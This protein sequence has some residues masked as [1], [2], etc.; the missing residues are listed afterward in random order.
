M[1][2]SITIEMAKGFS[3]YMVKAILNGRTDEIV[4]LAKTNLWIDRR[5]GMS[6]LGQ[7]QTLS[8]VEPM[9]ALPRKSGHWLSV[10]GC[11][12]CAKSGHSAA[13]SIS[14]SARIIKPIGTSI[15]SARAV[16]RLM[17]SL[18]AVG[19]SPGLAPL[20]IRST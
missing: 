14:L 15:P 2:P 17:M 7:R 3:L 16:V 20:R 12:L 10:S 6:A 8:R 1:P 19:R 4:D 9:S 11:P 18:N 13:Y 5:T